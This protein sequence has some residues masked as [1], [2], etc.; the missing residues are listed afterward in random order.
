[1]VIAP[2]GATPQGTPVQTA[3]HKGQTD[4][5]HAQSQ[6]M[7][8]K[9]IQLHEIFDIKQKQIHTELNQDFA[10]YIQNIHKHNIVIILGGVLTVNYDENNQQLQNKCA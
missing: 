3:H 9:L 6:T 5:S 4:P 2:L 10:L 8:L 7:A 1:M